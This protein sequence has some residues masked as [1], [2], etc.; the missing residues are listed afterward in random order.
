MYSRADELRI[1]AALRTSDQVDIDTCMGAP[2]GTLP[3]EAFVHPAT[4]ARVF[5]DHEHP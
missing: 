5:G 4:L 3:R 2:F 1:R